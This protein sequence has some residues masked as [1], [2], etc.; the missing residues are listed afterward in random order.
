VELSAD[1]ARRLIAGVDFT[2]RNRGI[3]AAATYAMSQPSAVAKY[4]IV[5]YCWGGST[6]W[7]HAVHNGAPGFGGAVAYYGLPFM[8]GAVPNADSLAKIR[9]PV[10]LLN[11]SADARIGAAMPAVDSAMKT[12]GKPYMGKNY[13]G[14]IHGF[15]RAQDDPAAQGGPAPAGPANLAAAKD[16]WPMTVAFFRQHLGR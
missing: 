8:N 10:M 5:G 1:T 6:S 15:L 13:E 11:G 2:E 7:G 14:A 3:V 9:V 16:A 12:L 4:G